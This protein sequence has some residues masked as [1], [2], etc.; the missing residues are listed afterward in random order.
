MNGKAKRAEIARQECNRNPIFLLQRGDVV[1]T[2]ITD[3][4]YS[5]DTE[6]YYDIST[7]K[8]VSEEQL[9]ERGVAG[10][11]W[12]TES[13]WFTRGEA[14]DFVEKRSYRYGKKGKDWMV[15]CVCVE[16]KLKGIL[17]DAG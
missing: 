1:V 16:S 4:S 13:V 6:E 9:L 2:A 5:S 10:I 15:Y 7:G 12:R 8:R 11:N 17:E 3:I 14:E